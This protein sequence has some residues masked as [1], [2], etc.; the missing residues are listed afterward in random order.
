MK[1][2]LTLSIDKDLVNYAKQQ[3]KRDGQSVSSMFSGILRAKQSQANKQPQPDIDSM[4][5]SLSRYNIDDS[6]VAIR[7]AYARKYSH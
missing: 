6:K 2:K 7:G 5:G 1:T 3:A 4:V